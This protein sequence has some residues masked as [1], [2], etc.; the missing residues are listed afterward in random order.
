MFQTYSCEAETP[1]LLAFSECSSL[2]MHLKIPFQAVKDLR[3]KGLV[4]E[5][6]I[7]Q[8]HIFAKKLTKIHDTS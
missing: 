5:Q 6:K 3:G 8:F 7:E 4:T 2:I 1:T